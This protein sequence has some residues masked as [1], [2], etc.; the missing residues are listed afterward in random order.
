MKKT[1]GK[2]LKQD[3]ERAY[4]LLLTRYTKTGIAEL[5]GIR[6]QAITRWT[7]VPLKYVR[8]LSEA[9]GIPKKNLRPSDFS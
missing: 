4:R 2:N 9:T 5:L 3:D 8:T 7:S 6:K 1:L